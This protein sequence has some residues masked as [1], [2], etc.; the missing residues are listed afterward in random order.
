MLYKLNK[1]VTLT[2][3]YKR[4]K[5]NLIL[6]VFGLNLYVTKKGVELC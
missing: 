3:F 2:W 1:I 4:L 6:E 5:Y